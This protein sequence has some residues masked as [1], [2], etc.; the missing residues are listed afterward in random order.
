MHADVAEVSQKYI[1]DARKLCDRPRDLL[2]T[3]EFG[4][5]EKVS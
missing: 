5:F 3:I 2:S 1:L 4:C